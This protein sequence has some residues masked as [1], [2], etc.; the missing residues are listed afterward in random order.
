MAF[1][2]NDDEGI[3]KMCG[4]LIDENPESYLGY[5]FFGEYCYGRHR[6]QESLRHC[7]KALELN[8]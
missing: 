3:K 4:Q 8:S 2:T 1:L 5:K 7:K 6:Y